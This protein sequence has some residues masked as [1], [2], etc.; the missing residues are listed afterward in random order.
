MLGCWLRLSLIGSSNDRARNSTKT[1]TKKKKTALISLTEFA[2]LPTSSVLRHQQWLIRKIG[3]LHSR[4][5]LSILTML[6]SSYCPLN[7]VLL[8]KIKF[9]IST[10]DLLYNIYQQN[11]L[12]TK[13]ARTSRW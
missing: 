8:L 4:S 12:K 11:D 9:H 7:Y 3:Q 1:K 6:L 2:F 13:P 5:L 10:L